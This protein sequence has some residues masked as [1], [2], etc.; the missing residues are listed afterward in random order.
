MPNSRQAKRIWWLGGLVL[1]LALLAHDVLMASVAHAAPVESAVAAVHGHDS[2]HQPSA[3]KSA[4]S[5]HD[6]S[7]DHPSECGTTGSAVPTSG[8]QLSF[9]DAGIL[10][11]VAE[12]DLSALRPATAR[13]WSEPFWPPG[14]LRALLQVYRI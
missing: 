1:V 6:R 11:L 12:A 13:G 8:S 3:M 2:A 9:S 4:L 7:P 14:A 10:A 5:P